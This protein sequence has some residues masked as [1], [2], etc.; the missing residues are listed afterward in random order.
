[1]QTL[2]CDNEGLVSELSTIL[3]YMSL[4]IC[5]SK[6]DVLHLY[7]SKDEVC[8][9]RKPCQRKIPKMKL[10]EK[11]LRASH[12]SRQHIDAISIDLRIEDI[13]LKCT[14]DSKIFDLFCKEFNKS[15]VCA[16]QVFS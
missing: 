8:S 11:Y 16:L 9:L 1:M 14:S 13:F 10:K 6:L 15:T 12:D 5:W 3:R 7:E 4:Y 2:T